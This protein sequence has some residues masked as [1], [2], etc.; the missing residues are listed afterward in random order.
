MAR[1]LLLVLLVLLF[2]VGLLRSSDGRFASFIRSKPNG[3]LSPSTCSMQPKSSLRGDDP[4]R[5]FIYSS[6]SVL[7]GRR[8]CSSDFIG[9]KACEDG[10]ELTKSEKRL[11][12][13]EWMPIDC[14]KSCRGGR[15]RYATALI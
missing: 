9:S 5:F 7:S 8:L 12:T 14:R 13:M 11:A 2:F 4:Y 3:S 6:S 10:C 15:N 1:I